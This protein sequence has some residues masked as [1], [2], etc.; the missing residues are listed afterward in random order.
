MPKQ[1][2]TDD[3]TAALNALY[4]YLGPLSV[5]KIASKSG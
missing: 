2:L 4:N 5:S 3:E 1:K